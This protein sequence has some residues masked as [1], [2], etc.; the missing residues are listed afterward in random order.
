M[1]APKPNN[2]TCSLP[3]AFKTLY[4]QDV[5]ALVDGKRKCPI[6]LRFVSSFTNIGNSITFTSNTTGNVT[7]EISSQITGSGTYT[8]NPYIDLDNF[9]LS[10]E[11]L[12]TVSV[13]S[14]ESSQNYIYGFNTQE[15]ENEIY[16]EGNSFSAEF[17]QYDGRLGKR[18]NLDPVVKEYESPYS[19]FSDNP[20]YYIDVKGDDKNSRHLDPDGKIIADYG[21]DKD[22]NV[23]KHQTARTKEEVDKWRAHF[24]NTSGNGVKVGALNILLLDGIESYNPSRSYYSTK[25]FQPRMVNNGSFSFTKSLIGNQLSNGSSNIT[26][27]NFSVKIG[28]LSVVGGSGPFSIGGSMLGMLQPIPDDALVWEAGR[29]VLTLSG[30][31]G[32]NLSFNDFITGDGTKFLSF[33]GFGLNGYLG[34]GTMTFSN[35]KNYSVVETF[36]SGFTTQYDFGAAFW[37]VGY[38]FTNISGYDGPRR[39]ANTLQYYNVNIHSYAFGSP[40]LNIGV[41]NDAVSKSLFFVLPAMNRKDSI[42]QAKKMFLHPSY[43][44]NDSTINRYSR[45]R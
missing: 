13:N 34:G 37:F 42:E 10:W 35:I 12:V 41:S 18:W 15:R 39:N 3:K 24:N 25:Q 8:V 4:L 5:Q 44:R 22:N 30:S 9:G 17:W 26:S 29:K 27:T 2:K 21:D 33:N 23:Y 14:C 32:L 38:N 36:N 6:K 20:I 7:I 16:G 28:Y 43:R 19:C 45:M 1:H 40:T 31:L 11:D